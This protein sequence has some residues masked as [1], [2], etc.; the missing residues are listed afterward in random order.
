[1]K[2][3]ALHRHGSFK[4]RELCSKASC[5][6]EC[7][8]GESWNLGTA[9]QEGTSQSPRLGRG[10]LN[11]FKKKK[12]L[13]SLW[14]NNPILVHVREICMVEQKQ[15]SAG[16]SPK[17]AAC[18]RPKVGGGHYPELAS[19]RTSWEAPALQRQHTEEIQAQTQTSGQVN[20]FEIVLNA[21]ERI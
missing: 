4:E 3:N 10:R 9:S 16:C 18:Y 14:E 13:G 19:P 7:R 20:L 12:K 5:W 8:P 17:E 21:K 6:A 15:E 2:P 11:Q 1:M